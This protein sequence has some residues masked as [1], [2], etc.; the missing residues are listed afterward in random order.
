ME[1]IADLHLH[2][3]F[4]IATGKAADL[5][6]LDLWG[7][8]KGVQVVGTGDCT[9]PE[10][11]KE[12]AARLEPVAPG[13]YELKPDLAL[14]LQLQGPL[15]DRVPA[16]RFVITGEVSCIYKKG[17]QVRKVHLL[18][19]LPSLEAAQKF[20]ARLG[21]LGN[22]TADGRP[23]LGL[24]AKYI[25]ELALEI[26]PTA[27]VIPAHIWTPWFSVLG[28]K[29]GFD[30][31]EECFEEHTSRIH[32]LETGLSSDPAMNWRVSSLDRFLLVS[33]SDAHSPQK[34]AREANIFLVPPTFPDLARA[35]RTKAGFGGTIEFFPQEGKYHLD[36]HRACGLRATP[37][38]TAAW[39]GKCPQCRKPLTYGVMHRVQDLADRRPGEQPPQA[40]PFE[41]L[42]PLP[43]VLG[44]VLEA[45]PGTKKVNHLYFRV[46]EKLGP[47]LEILRR[48]SLE[49]LAREG[50]SLLAYGMDKMRQGRV[51]IAPGYDG[52]YGEIR[53]FTPE[54]RQEILGQGALWSPPAPGP[55][56]GPA[57][58]APQESKPED[59][60]S[61]AV[62][63][64]APEI[65]ADPW[66]AGLNPAQRQAV[67]HAGPPLIVHAGPGT[68][69]TR[70]LTH[71]LAHLLA[72]RRVPPE[73]I[74]A[75]TF[76]RQAAGEMEARIQG[77]LPD[78]PGLERLTIKTFH[79][80]G[81]QILA[82]QE[83]GREVADEEQRR[84]LLRQA[85]KK[86]KVPAGRLDDR[87][88]E[89]KQALKYPEDLG[90]V[91][92]PD[93]VAFQDYEA[94]L[95]REGLWDYED[96]I[97]RP[98]L[99]L[100]RRPGMQ[101]AYRRRCRHLLV[102]EYQDLNAAQYRL[103]RALAGP[104][105]EIMVIG[106]PDQAIYGFRGASPRYF[107]HFRQDW[108][109][110]VT[111]NF[112]ETYRL[113]P[114]VLEAAR[115]VRKR[116]GAAVGSMRTHQ[117]GDQPVL[118]L[119]RA[120]E[121]AEA[122][123]IAKEI[124][125]LVGGLSHLALE[126][127]AVRHR[128]PEEKAGFRDVAVLYRLHA[129][130]PELERHLTAQGIPCQLPRESVGPELDGLDLAAEKVKL[131]TLHAAKGLEFPY[132]FIAGCEAGLLPWEPE[133]DGYQDPEE[134]NRLFYVGLTRASR[135]VFL[136]RARTRSLWGKKR[137]TLLSPLVQA[138]TPDILEPR[139]ESWAASSRKTRQPQLF[140]EIGPRGKKSH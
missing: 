130:G 70:A 104:G 118:L 116:A 41:S 107:A 128:S 46:L 133:G 6:H 137:R 14:P 138:L 123:A 68:G 12:L 115:Q 10:W 43:E 57:P 56:P 5:E 140:P 108:P 97:A 135:Q 7:R 74:L 25:L 13:T 45:N 81:H 28:A 125:R 90:A 30:S 18:L 101:E 127:A 106:D 98:T 47:E 1:V 95:R 76:T 29:S 129:L 71:R 112:E 79:A 103:F 11:L 50:G 67:L 84:Q 100:T 80:L 82:A 34:L 120:T 55:P 105:A 126:D 92:E 119:E 134:E 59:A 114:P 109:D 121:A 61:H 63:E 44:Q 88:M 131:L 33:N 21:R 20:S 86:H 52:V 16:V 26:D 23:I 87:I 22:V 102:D 93:A 75:L 49:D 54:E 9:H 122:R 85:A 117:D 58:S 31:L 39:G 17:G 124:E 37:E 8:Y 64:P 15:W 66:L 36:G 19:L 24:D 65:P 83:E 40:R 53:L 4:S 35:L 3:R 32:A 96:L 111:L 77:L 62:S 136:T 38:E 72:G 42:I 69:K 78:F 139:Q 48:A 60:R 89:W 132:V 91:N 27:L 73:E 110:A 99:L 2:S 113:P 94:L 51:H